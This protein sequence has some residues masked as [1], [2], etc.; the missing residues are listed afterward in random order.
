MCSVLFLAN[1][2][3]KLKWALLIKICPLSVVVVV[4]NFSHF[5]LLQHLFPRGDYY[6][7]AKIS[8]TEFKNLLQNHWANFNQ[9]WHN[10][11]LGE[12]N[13]I[14][15]KEGPHS[16]LKGDIYEIAKIYWLNLKMF[17]SRII[18]PCSTKL[19]T[20]HSWVMVI[21][22]FVQKKGHTLLQVEMI[23]K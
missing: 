1:P 6:E 2:R 16:F 9:T 8:L 19:N 20:K 18:G 11:C 13:L 12:G 3:Q 15:S 7:M 21:H 22:K 17:F 4:I 23:M 10:A 14:Y 5:H